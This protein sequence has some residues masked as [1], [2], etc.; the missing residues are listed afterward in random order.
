MIEPQTLQFGAHLPLIDFGEGPR[1]VG[2]LSAYAGQ[3]AALDFQYLCAND[4]LLFS[5]P[6]LDGPTALAAVLQSS[7]DMTIATTVA[8][9][10]VRGPVQT[11]KTLASLDVLSGGRLIAG[12][13]PGSSARDYAAAD[14]PFSERWVRFDEAVRALRALLGPDEDSFRGALYSTDGVD[15]QPRPPR[16][17]P[18]WI[19]SW[20]SAAGIRRVAQLGD[21]WLA[22]AYNTTPER[23]AT[24]LR[25]LSH[26]LTTCG[27][28]PA[29]FPHA[30]AT[31]W[32]Y[33]TNTRRD[34]DRQLR[35]V[36]APLLNRPVEA[37]RALALAIGPAEQC[38]EHISAYVQA[39][40]QRFFLWPLA[41]ELRQLQTFREHVVPLI[42]T[43]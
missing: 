31:M 26:R 3:A 37:L 42:S 30:I 11:A 22:S 28:G 8:L 41:D 19:A 20:G 5:R 21:G 12:V 40:A 17:P 4:H 39:G 35:D 32:L 1:T 9:P 23:F 2:D 10:V 16:R 15:L 38:A 27:D 29:V 14:V 33:V 18:I 13:G 34:A 36:L 43:T 6:W 24:A 25:T 7:G